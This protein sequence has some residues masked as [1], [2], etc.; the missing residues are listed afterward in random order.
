MKQSVYYTELASKFRTGTLSQ[1]LDQKLPQ[2]EEL[3]DWSD[4][5]LGS[6]ERNQ[7]VFIFN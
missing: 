3:P 4:A 1:L 6:A 7:P 2:Y 5:V